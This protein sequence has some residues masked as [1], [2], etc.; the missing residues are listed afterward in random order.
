MYRSSC[1]LFENRLRLSLGTEM[2][3]ILFFLFYIQRDETMKIS[4]Y[5]VANI[6]NLHFFISAVIRTCCLVTYCLL[7]S[8]DFVILYDFI[9]FLFTSVSLNYLISESFVV[10]RFC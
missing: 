1:T 5:S 6:S 3:R 10:F 2:S 4:K 8:L 7:I 9:S